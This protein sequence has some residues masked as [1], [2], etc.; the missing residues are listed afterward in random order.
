MSKKVILCVDDEK[1]ILD[2]LKS[3][4]KKRF[5]S[6]YMYEVAENADEAFEVIEELAE[7]G[8][9]ILIIVSDW[10]MPGMK[11]DEFLIHIHKMFPAIVKVMLTGQ[12]DEE[13]VEN[14]RRN[15]DLHR[16]L[17]KPWTEEEL[18]DTI[19]SGLEKV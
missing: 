3:Q 13:A 6:E 10:L 15:A 11:G 18:V 16:C 17:Y 19:L 2:S 1:I 14:V 12:A 7:D 8:L 9:E 5:A 4:L